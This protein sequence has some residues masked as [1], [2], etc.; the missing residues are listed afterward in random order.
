METLKEVLI[1]TKGLSEIEALDEIEIIKSLILKGESPSDILI[2]RFGI[3][4]S[5][6]QDLLSPKGEL[7]E[8]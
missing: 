8:S 4:T 3:D 7:I 1:R 2:N 6:L 5:F